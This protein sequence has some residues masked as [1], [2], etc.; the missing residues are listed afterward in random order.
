MDY[1]A[2]RPTSRDEQFKELR[3]HFAR[4]YFKNLYPLTFISAGMGSGKTRFIANLHH[5]IKSFRGM[6]FFVVK[7]G[8]LASQMVKSCQDWDEDKSKSTLI[9]VEAHHDKKGKNGFDALTDMIDKVIFQGKIPALL[10]TK[11]AHGGSA[12]NPSGRIFEK[13]MKRYHS[14][15]K[16]VQVDEL[17][18]M[19]TEITG[20]INSKV[21]HHADAVD[22]HGKVV[23]QKES[24]N[25]FDICR[26]HGAKVFG[27]SGTLNNAISSKIPSTG[28]AVQEISLLSC[29]PIPALYKNL[30][31]TDKLK[32]IPTNT[33]DFLT[34]KPYLD[35]AEKS[36]QKIL[37]IFAKE[38]DI[39][40]FCATYHNIYKRSISYKKITSEEKCDTSSDEF[41]KTLADAK[42]VIGINK[43]SVGFDLST[44]IKGEQFCLG[45]MFRGM[46]DKSSQPL[47]KNEC[48]TLHMDSAASF[49]QILARPREG[50]IFLVPSDYDSR[51]LYDRL[52]DVFNIIHHGHNDCLWVGPPRATQSEREYQGILQATL[53]NLKENNRSVVEDVLSRLISLDGRNL[54]EERKRAS[55]PE[56][57]DSNYWI[58]A[59]EVVW[60]TFRIIR[61]GS[62]RTEE[63][64][65]EAKKALVDAHRKRT[66]I[67]SGGGLRDAREME[68]EVREQ[69]KARAEG[70]CGHCGFE[71]EEDE[72]T[73]DGHFKRHD[74]GGTFTLDNIMRVHKS[75]DCSY[76]SSEIIH[77]PDGSV[78][79]HRRCQNHRPDMKQVAGISKENIL[80]R[81]NWVKEQL[82][83][84]GVSDDEFTRFLTEKKYVRK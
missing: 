75:C 16:V 83:K 76:D 28:H 10:F 34:I 52:D 64:K 30:D 40:K 32:V 7:D 68:A 22:S 20:G 35:M 47:S 78:F 55:T 33:R 54:E 12:F 29:A 72:E 73:Q 36:P 69:V 27:L 37:L 70:I 81:W 26:K 59:I 74:C 82:G 42:Y 19:L 65:V 62:M 15:D 50:G 5:F 57:F 45:I 23:D 84:K 38:E 77:A 66:I 48:H 17:D 39:K 13:L 14:S 61:D 21:D 46:D 79:L 43:L 67:T 6:M 31:G 11:I 2:F 71:L 60:G 1:H 4:L 8:G 9:R 18:S 51:S 56:E 25:A 58:S 53:Q 3:N 80:A 24:L 44:F 49:L 63:Q 41:I